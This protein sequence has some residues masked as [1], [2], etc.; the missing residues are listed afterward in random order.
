MVSE[1]A[2][3]PAD[4]A[5]RAAPASRP[6]V[7]RRAPASRPRVARRAPAAPTAARPA[8]RRRGHWVWEVVSWAFAIGCALLA[9]AM[10]NNMA[11]A[12][13]FISGNGKIT[14][15]VLGEAPAAAVLAPPPPPTR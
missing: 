15:R 11:A 1:P 7:A 5:T 8:A 2:P 10:M 9:Y 3:P 12:A 4:R 6:R 13:A 14:V